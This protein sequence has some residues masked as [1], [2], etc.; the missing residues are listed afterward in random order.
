V[1]LAL[2]DASTCVVE[3]AAEEIGQVSK[4]SATGPGSIGRAGLRSNA[5]SCCCRWSILDHPL[6]V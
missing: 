4:R 3:L 5:A 1:L 6:R 2:I